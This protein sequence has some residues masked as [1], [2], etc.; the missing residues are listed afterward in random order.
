M[1]YNRTFW[2]DHVV[3]QHGEVIQQGT[4]MDQQHF[5]N[6]EQGI[7]D[8]TLAGAIMQ[9][10]QMQ[11]GYN[12]EDELHTLDLAMNALPWP[13]NNTPTTVALNGL[14]ESTNYSV[15][16]NVLSY[17]GGRLGNIRVADRACNGFKLIHDGS[18]TT[19]RV[20]VRVS[21]GMIDPMSDE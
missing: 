19:V 5:N 1:A 6:A 2:V 16:C 21:G 11:S 13:F 8:M 12:I 18:A 10:E 17:S 7:A 20:A 9:F 3:D 14:R 15:E 4:L